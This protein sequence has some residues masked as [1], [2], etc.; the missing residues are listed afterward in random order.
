MVML[1]LKR[2]AT[3]LESPSFSRVYSELF[4]HSSTVAR[5]E[6]MSGK[7]SSPQEKGG[8][9]PRP[10]GS[11]LRKKVTHKKDKVIERKGA[12]P[13]QLYHPQVDHVVEIQM[14]NK[15][16]GYVPAEHKSPQAKAQMEQ[17]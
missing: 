16:W 9:K 2:I 7:G 10:K 8:A 14:C 15:A 1:F 13:S 3:I 11:G 5:I 12:S 4:S 6:A 17:V